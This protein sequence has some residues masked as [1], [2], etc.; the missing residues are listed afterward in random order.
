MEHIPDCN[1]YKDLS[2]I[3]H[4]TQ[5]MPPKHQARR[6]RDDHDRDVV[7]L[8]RAVLPRSRATSTANTQ[9]HAPSAALVS[10][11][12]TGHFRTL[13]FGEAIGFQNS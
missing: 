12:P 2:D 11:T 10:I 1:I 6:D 7:A 9:R 13:A 8:A 4:Q 5:Q 3:G